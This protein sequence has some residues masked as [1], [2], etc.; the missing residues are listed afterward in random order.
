M[1]QMEPTEPVFHSPL[2]L[3]LIKQKQLANAL[4]TEMASTKMA[5]EGM[6]LSNLEKECKNIRI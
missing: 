5:I 4:L 3:P 2:L 1:S 6:L